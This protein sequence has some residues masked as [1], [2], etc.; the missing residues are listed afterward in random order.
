MR[1]PACG[2]DEDRVLD[3]RPAR[4]GA[5]IRRRRECSSCQTRF[6]TWE[7]IEGTQLTVVKTDG[8]R[9]VYSR[10]KLG[11][12]LERAL[13]K[14]PHTEEQIRELVA[15]IERAILAS[16]AAT[17]EISSSELGEIVLEELRSFDEVGYIRFASV[18][19]RFQDVREFVQ[20]LKVFD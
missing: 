8:G 10:A 2:H 20:E 16:G 9:E 11:R 4:D 12:G 14:R 7:Y 18:Y 6:T 13:I 17:G 3:S 1:C 5:A 15:R 19:R